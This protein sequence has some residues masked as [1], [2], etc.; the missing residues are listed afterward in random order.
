MHYSIEILAGSVANARG[1][2][3]CGD[4]MHGP[5]HDLRPLVEGGAAR[6]IHG[7]DGEEALQVDETLWGLSAADAVALIADTTDG[8]ML[9][10][11]QT[12]ESRNPRYRPEGRK[13]VRDAIA[14]QLAQLKADA[15][16]GEED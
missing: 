7:P 6:W 2:F 3:A 16:P 10:E 12:G 4:T 13:T 5:E 15:A 1:T 11:W 8:A 9:R 14:G